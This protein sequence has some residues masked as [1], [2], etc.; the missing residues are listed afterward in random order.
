MTV[1]LPSPGKKLRDTEEGVV[2]VVWLVDEDE[3]WVELTSTEDYHSE[4]ERLSADEFR[5]QVESK[6]LKPAD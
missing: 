5:E 1:L 2:K 4:I 6:R 3:G